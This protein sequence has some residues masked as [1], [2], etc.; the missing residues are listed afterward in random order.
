MSGG[1]MLVFVTILSFLVIGVAL[2]MDVK[3]T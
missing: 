3:S 2:I 1:E